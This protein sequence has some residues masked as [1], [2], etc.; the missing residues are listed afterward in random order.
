MAQKTI[1][2]NTPL[3]LLEKYRQVLISNGIFVQKL[4]I[5]G[6]YSRGNPKPWSDID[7]CVV[8]P[9]FGSDGYRES[10]LLKKLANT[11]DPMIEPHPYNPKD[12]ANPLDPLAHEILNT[13]KEV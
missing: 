7:V 5:F 10:V 8:S 2:T 9:D 12:L 1:L 13:G 3:F 6:S 11:V 4:I